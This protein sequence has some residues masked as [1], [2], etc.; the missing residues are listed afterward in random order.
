MNNK[1]VI[2][3]V[4][5]LV[6]I[7]GVYFL[8]K[9]SSAPAPYSQSGKGRVVVAIK[10]AAQNMGTISSVVVTVNKVQLGS[11]ENGWITVSTATKNYD[12]IAL[13]QSNITS[14]YGDATV[15]AG[16]YNQI[17]LDISKV[18]ITDNGVAHD[19]K[20]PSGVLKI[21]GNFVVKDGQTSTVVFDFKA[22]KSIHITGNGKYIFA[23]VIN[24]EVKG[25]VKVDINEKDEVES[26]EGDKEI[27]EDF[28]M[29]E[30]GEVKVNFEAKDLDFEN[31]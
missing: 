14:L 29:D 7:G 27:D 18:V 28:G 24:L 19:A 6:I 4:A 25:D 13:K 17:R 16:T 26:A 30:K 22:D 15:P 1:V 5:L 3:I 2:G 9:K 10:D 23:P 12:L 31:D 11:E 20:L 21:D 8:S